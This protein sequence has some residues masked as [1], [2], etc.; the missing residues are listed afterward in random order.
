MCV[1]TLNVK[2]A[3][4]ITEKTLLPIISFS[5][6]KYLKMEQWP[7]NNDEIMIL[8]MYEFEK[9]IRHY[10]LLFIF[11]IIWPIFLV[12]FHFNCPHWHHSA[13]CH[14]QSGSIRL[15]MILLGNGVEI[16]IGRHNGSFVIV[17]FIKRCP[18][19]TKVELLTTK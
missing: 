3:I 15:S 19:A 14:C 9:R 1:L 16:K 8:V 13:I 7:D 12:T 18:L 17:I 2:R 10:I 6:K 5:V 11:T 4:I